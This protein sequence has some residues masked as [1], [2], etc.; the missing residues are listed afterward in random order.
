MRNRFEERLAPESTIAVKH[1]AAFARKVGVAE[2]KG[3]V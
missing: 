1:F 2:I 3:A